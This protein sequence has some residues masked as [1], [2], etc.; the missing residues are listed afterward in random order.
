MIHKSNTTTASTT[1]TIET[2]KPVTVATRATRATARAA[3]ATT[4]HKQYKQQQREQQQQ[5]QEEHRQIK[6]DHK[7][8]PHTTQQPCELPIQ[9]TKS[10]VSEVQYPDHEI[11]HL[12]RIVTSRDRQ[13]CRLFLD[14]LL[15]SPHLYSSVV[16]SSLIFSLLSYSLLFTLPVSLL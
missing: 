10:E 11:L 5:E 9:P 3:T 1:S 15:S 2:N 6:H 7:T 12:Q 4:A 16:S 14:S 8:T 13:Y